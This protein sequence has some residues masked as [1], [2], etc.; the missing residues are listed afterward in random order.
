MR[1]KFLTGGVLRHGEEGLAVD[2]VEDPLGLDVLFILLEGEELGGAVD[3]KMGNSRVILKKNLLN[4][5][6]AYNFER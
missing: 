6:G 1:G 3:D 2:A 5:Y 4:L